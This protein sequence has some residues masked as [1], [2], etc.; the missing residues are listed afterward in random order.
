MS[1]D[2]TLEPPR[3]QRPTRYPA[4]LA[5]MIPSSLKAQIVAAAAASSQGDVVRRWLVAGRDLEEALAA[6]PDLTE[7]V[8]RLGR[9]SG[10]SMADALG[11]LLDFA[12]READR[13][14]ERHA[15]IAGA[16]GE[17]LA[18]DGIPFDGISVGDFEI[19]LDG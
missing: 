2:A 8:V 12:T 5:A 7:R 16:V 6:H 10:V 18:S 19:S 4:H 11:K 17:A 15:K 14:V 3:P 1:D 13:R 9:E